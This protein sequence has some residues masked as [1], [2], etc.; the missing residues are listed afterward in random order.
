MFAVTV[1]LWGFG[2]RSWVA[3]AVA[4][5]M[6]WLISYAMFG[7]MHDAAAKQM[8]SW[9]GARQAGAGNDER[10]EDAEVERAASATRKPKTAATSG[11]RSGKRAS[12]SGRSA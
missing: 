9:L 1:V 10:A 4:A 6:A 11:S 5:L 3:V 12:S 8:E 2:I 7:S